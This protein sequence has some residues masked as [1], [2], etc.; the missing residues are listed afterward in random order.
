[1]LR[2]SFI[3]LHSFKDFAVG[4]FDFYLWVNTAP[5]AQLCVTALLYNGQTLSPFVPVR[6][7]A[8]GTP[9]GPLSPLLPF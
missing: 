7:W 3:L 1:M 8:P 6:P 4:P 2:L 5:N 9:M